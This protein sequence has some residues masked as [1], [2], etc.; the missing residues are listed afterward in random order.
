MLLTNEMLNAK[1]VVHYKKEECDIY[2]IEK[3]D[4]N[5]V[6]GIYRGNNTIY[7]KVTLPFV[8]WDCESILYYPFGYFVFAEDENKLIEKIKIKMNELKSNVIG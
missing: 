7:A 2:I 6:I 4:E 5:Y 1:K 8:R 3:N